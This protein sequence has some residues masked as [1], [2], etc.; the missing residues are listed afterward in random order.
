MTTSTGGFDRVK[1]LKEFDDTKA[2]VKGLVD[3]G[4][5]TIPAIFRHPHLHHDL[6]PAASHLSI[7]TVDLSLPRS[8][9]IDHIVS[10]SKQWG[11]F[12]VVNHGIPLSA[13]ENTISAIR[14]F[15]E[16]PA[17]VRSQHYT[18]ERVGGVSYS[19]N[20]DLFRA[21]AASWRDTVQIHMGPVRPEVDRIP[22]VCRAETLAW[23]EHAKEIAREV[24]GMMCEGLGLDTRRM[25][26]MSCLEDRLMVCH[27][28]APCPEPDRTFGIVD[29]TD[30]AVLTVLIQDM[31]GGLQV[32]KEEDGKEVWVDVKPIPGALVI[33]VGEL[34]QIIS[35]DIYKSAGHRVVANSH[36]DARVSIAI[37][38]NPGKRGESDLYGPLPELISSE[39]GAFY[40]NFTISEY[41]GAF[42]SKELRSKT[43]VEQ[44][45]L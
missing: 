28:Y 37:F 22:A 17:D 8:T 27:Y 16:L 1:A 31:I 40:Q 6:S 34:L 41:M 15:H 9:V 43:L 24:M 23:D 39:K 18:R 30:A 25:E 42:I 21:R 7:P 13:I 36:Q 10:A 26:E 3:S 32:K 4:I 12:Q 29:H 38:Y 5:T 19:S 14:S 45:K 2:G 33:N 11:F 20:L 44:F 35:N